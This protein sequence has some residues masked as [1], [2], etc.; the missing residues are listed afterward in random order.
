[1]FTKNYA[2]C[3]IDPLALILA[4][5]GLPVRTLDLHRVAL[6]NTSPPSR[7]PCASPRTYFNPVT[8]RRLGWSIPE[9][10]GAQRVLPCRQVGD[11]DR[12]RVLLMSAMEM[13]GRRRATAAVAVFV[14]TTRRTS[15]CRYCRR[16]R[17]RRTTATVLSG[18]YRLLCEGLGLTHVH[19]WLAGQTWR[20]ACAASWSC[21]AGAGPVPTE[22]L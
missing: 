22:L 12:R 9:A 10:I 17:T 2:R 14:W 20:R 13:A 11:A 6:P 1:L 19:A 3:G 4:C 18:Y 21:A 8:T 5:A 7:L 16:R 15:T